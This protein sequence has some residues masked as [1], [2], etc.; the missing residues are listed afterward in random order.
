[1]PDFILDSR[2]YLTEAI[3]V[4]GRILKQKTSIIKYPFRIYRAVLFHA[5]LSVILFTA[6]C[7][8]LVAQSAIGAGSEYP[9]TPNL[10]I[11][12][13]FPDE[14][15]SIIYKCNEHSPKQLYVIG[16][17]HRDTLTGLNGT[18]TV[19]SQVEVYRITEGL[20]KSKGLR[21]I[22]PEGYFSHT[23]NEDRAVLVRRTTSGAGEVSLDTT[24]LKT[25]LTDDAVHA[26]AELLLM[27]SYDII[28]KPVEDTELYNAVRSR[29]RDLE[30]EAGVFE[31]LY[32]RS[33]L[34]Y[35]QERRVAAMLQKIPDVIDKEYREGSISAENAVFTIGMHHIVEIV[36]YLKNRKIEI[37]SP[38]FTSFEDYTADVSLLQQDFG[39]TVI[40]PHSLAGAGDLTLLTKLQESQ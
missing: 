40:V 8:V 27:E 16:M 28:L 25:R 4:R 38:A 3:Y 37:P 7:F 23:D 31:R 5:R 24:I 11:E 9:S 15:G 39:V 32:I 19:D 33:E 18:K 30:K 26:N 35:L 29:V 1:M 6:V 36:R 17:S 22:L 2:P 21:L 13:P 34:D 14:Y 12:T 10:A 20:I